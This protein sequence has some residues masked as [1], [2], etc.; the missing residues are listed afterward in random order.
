MPRRQSA[1]YRTIAGLFERV[2]AISL[3]NFTLCF[4]AVLSCYTRKTEAKKGTVTRLGAHGQ[5]QCGTA[6]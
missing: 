2:P 6:D 4:K 3:T 1:R 5:T